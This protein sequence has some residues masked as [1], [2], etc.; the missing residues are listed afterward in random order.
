MSLPLSSQGFIVKASDQTKAGWP[1]QHSD[2]L[3]LLVSLQYL[4][5]N[6]VE[7]LVNATVFLNAPHSLFW[8]YY[9]WYVKAPDQLLDLG[10]AG[11]VS[12]ELPDLQKV[13]QSH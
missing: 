10:S 1:G 12:L 5:R 13:I 6:G 7:L 9:I 8:L 3:P 11:A 2:V 4:A